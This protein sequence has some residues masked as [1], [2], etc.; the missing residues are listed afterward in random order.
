MDF[1]SLGTFGQ[2]MSL[3]TMAKS[4]FLQVFP[5]IEWLLPKDL[6]DCWRMKQRGFFYPLRETISL[7][8][9]NKCMPLLTGTSRVQVVACQIAESSWTQFLHLMRHNGNL[10][11]TAFV[12]LVFLNTFCQYHMTSPF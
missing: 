12:P 4:K 9:C 2:L 7:V 1:S 3:D 8:D 10:I 6:H 5:F 11:V